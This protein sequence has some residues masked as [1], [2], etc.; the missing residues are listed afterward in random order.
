MKEIIGVILKICFK[1]KIK[2]YKNIGLENYFIFFFL[3]DI[4]NILIIVLP[5]H[6]C[7]YFNIINSKN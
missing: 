1:F 5:L 2:T 3:W 7:F 4:K 6:L